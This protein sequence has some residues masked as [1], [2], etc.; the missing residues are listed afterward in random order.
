MILSSVLICRWVYWSQNTA[1]LRIQRQNCIF[2]FY[3]SLSP[4]NKTSGNKDD[5]FFLF[6]LFID[7]YDTAKLNL[8]EKRK[9]ILLSWD[10]QQRFS[11]FLNKRHVVLVL[12]LKIPRQSLEDNGARKTV[13]F[14]L[15]FWNRDFSQQNLKRFVSFD[16]KGFGMTFVFFVLSR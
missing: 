7:T 10:F 13:F 2:C 16:T 12:V 4:L 1:G 8:S 15:P 6:Y 5:Y 9:T 11:F 14:S 3:D